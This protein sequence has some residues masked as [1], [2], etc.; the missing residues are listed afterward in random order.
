MK[1]VTSILFPLLLAAIFIFPS[2]A[3]A[4]V[5][6][7]KIDPY[8]A[9]VSSE[10]QINYKVE[11]NELHQARNDYI[12]IVFP[13]EAEL[14]NYVSPGNILIN[15]LHAKAVSVFPIQGRIDIL[16]PAC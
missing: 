14:P 15:T 9:G 12:T 7:L 3:I 6:A 4:G 13:T 5:E 8:L 11:G 1:K 2:A 16:V 10:Y